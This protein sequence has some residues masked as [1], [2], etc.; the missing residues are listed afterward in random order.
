MSDRYDSDTQ[1]WIDD[2]EL[3]QRIVERIDSDAAFWAG[4][5]R[6]KA[7][8]AISV[9]VDDGYVTLSGT[10][11]SASEKRRADLLARALGARGV[12]NRLQVAPEPDAS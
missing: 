10:V 9:D 7:K 4:Q 11:R 1:L 6:R 8:T 12:D 3:Q 5:S 2:E